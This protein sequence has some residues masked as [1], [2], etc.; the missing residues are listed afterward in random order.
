MKAGA[1]VR[2]RRLCLLTGACLSM[3]MGGLPSTSAA[4][5]LRV[6]WTEDGRIFNLRFSSDG[7]LGRR[8]DELQQAWRRSMDGDV[9]GTPIL[10]PNGFL[11]AGTSGANVHALA[12]TNGFQLW[13]QFVG[14]AVPGSV[15]FKNETVY[16]VASRVGSPRLV[17]LDPL[18]GDI[19]WSTIVDSQRDADAWGSPAYSAENNLIYVPICAC[20]AEEQRKSSVSTRGAVVAVHAE[21]GAIVWKTHTVPSNRNGGG[22][23]GTPLVVPD[24]GRIYVGT[25]HAYSGTAHENTDALLALDAATGAILGSFQAK[26]GDVAQPD[27]L[28]PT[29]RQGF[30]VAP[31]IFAI[32]SQAGVTFPVGAGAGNGVFYAVDPLTM[33]KIWETRVGVGSPDGGV[34][35]SGAWNGELLHGVTA[36]PTNY[37]GLR[38]NGSLAYLFPGNDVRHFGP[39]SWTHDTIYSTD[40]AGFLNTQVDDFGRPA[41]RYPLGAPSTGGV[42]FGR[43]MAFVGVGSERTA[44]Q[45]T[46]GAII[47]FK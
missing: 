34:V 23:A 6:P 28:D 12:Q 20:T 7:P 44:G 17:A 41:G 1:R 47:A 13:S 33:E 46:G 21:T 29:R 27:S 40:S 11:Y 16:A 9:T 3:V 10:A 24:F 5:S 14:G 38:P 43:R 18:T 4:Q 30:T 22:V 8:S 45:G 32:S 25:D 37:F 15:L 36:S 35:A 2:A 42:S 39:A 26:P 19:K 31:N